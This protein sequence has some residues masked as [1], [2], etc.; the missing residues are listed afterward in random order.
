MGAEK[1]D[2]RAY[3][4]AYMK[5]HTRP[6][7]WMLSNDDRDRLDQYATARGMKLS[8][9]LKDAVDADAKAHGLPPV[10]AIDSEVETETDQK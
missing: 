4:T 9:V 2:K 10:F 6:Y 3:D 7:H 5:A 8:A 1:F